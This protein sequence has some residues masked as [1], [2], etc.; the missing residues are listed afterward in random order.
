MPA[1][2]IGLSMPIRGRSFTPTA[3]VERAR[4]VVDQR[5]APVGDDAA[6]ADDDL[7]HVRC[8]GREH[9]RLQ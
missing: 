9:Q 3:R 1:R 6:A 5:V 2:R 7:A 4:D 8:G